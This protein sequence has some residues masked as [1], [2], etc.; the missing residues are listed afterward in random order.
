MFNVFLETKFKH[1]ISLIQHYCLYLTE[2]N[3]SSFNV[4]DN[5]PSSTNEDFYSSVKLTS[6]F[7][8]RNT[9]IDSDTS[10]LRRVMLELS[11]NFSYL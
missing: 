2:I 5:A 8:N 4:I 9:A 6:L 11:K 1:L 3:I 7:L 10:I